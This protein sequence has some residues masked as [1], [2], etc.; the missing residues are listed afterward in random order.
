MLI[1]SEAHFV[2]VG[3]QFARSN[4]GYEVAFVDRFGLRY[5]EGERSMTIP[6]DPLVDRVLLDLSRVSGWSEPFDH[7]VLTSE[8]RAR[9]AENVAAGLKRLRVGFEFG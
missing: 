6:L 2:E 4:R 1:E 5:S 7:E 8:A 9:I 3:A